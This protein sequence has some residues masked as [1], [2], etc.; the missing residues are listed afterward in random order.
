MVDMSQNF[1]NPENITGIPQFFQYVNNLVGGQAGPGLLLVVFVVSFIASKTDDTET[2]FMVSSVITF[3]ASWLM[4]MGGLVQGYHI[5]ITSLMILV[6]VMLK[7]G[8]R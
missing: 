2:A 3:G 6:S 4:L 7:A 1:A 8:R 5:V